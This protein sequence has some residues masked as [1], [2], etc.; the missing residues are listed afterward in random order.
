MLQ[1][2]PETTTFDVRPDDHLTYLMAKVGHLLE[3]RVDEAVSQAGLTLRQFSALAHIARRPGLS[4]SDLARSLLTTPQAVN[5]LVSRL[6]A[7]GLISRAPSLPRQPLVLTLTTSGVQA[8]Q[9]AALLASEA[10][11]AA[12]AGL[13]TGQLAAT[14]QTLE[15][16]LE[17]LNQQSAPGVP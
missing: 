3:R 2:D 16:L 8:L 12:L 7:A 11:T 14:R 15:L 6:E 9:R 4:S 13:E 1:D 5:T 10:E 17:Q